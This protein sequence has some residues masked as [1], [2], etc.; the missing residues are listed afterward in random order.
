MDE[1]PLPPS[2]T[3]SP[4]VRLLFVTCVV[5][6]FAYGAVSLVLVLYLTAV[7]LSEQET[8]LLLTMTL[9]GDT[10]LSLWITTIADRVGRKSMLIAGAAL[11]ILGGA[12]FAITDNFL[13][14]LLTATIGVLSPSGK[15]VGPF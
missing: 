15:E 10:V 4:D 11:M 6:L 5:R 1:A 14:L 7:G 9:I 13:L 2:G 12:G 8:G 3:R